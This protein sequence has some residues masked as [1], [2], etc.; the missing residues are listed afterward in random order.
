MEALDTRSDIYSLGV[1]L[2]YLISGKR[3]FSGTVGQVLI[4]QVVTPPPFE[5]LAQAPQPVIALLERM[6]RKNRDERFQTPQE[7]QE[8]VEAAAAKLAFRIR[9]GAGTVSGRSRND[10]IRRQSRAGD[11]GPG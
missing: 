8:A 6:L 9:C 3:P 1:T 10:S 11:G 2:W 5:Q 7:L 4:A